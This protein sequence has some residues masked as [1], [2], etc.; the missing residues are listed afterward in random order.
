MGQG[1]VISGEGP[2]PTRSSLLISESQLRR[3]LLW[4]ALPNCSGR[5][6]LLSPLGSCCCGL[7]HT[8]CV[9]PLLCLPPSLGGDEGREC[10]CVCEW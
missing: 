8:Q 10:V 7:G 5:A 9:P 3:C 6:C 2:Q 1:G 4:E